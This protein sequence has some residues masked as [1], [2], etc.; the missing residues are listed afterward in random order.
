MNEDGA[1][2]PNWWRAEKALSLDRKKRQAARATAAKPGDAF[3]IVT[4]GTVTEPVYFDLLLS[5]LHLSA[6]LIKVLPGD[7]TDPKRVILTAEREAKEQLRRS[8][9]GLLG[10]NEPA[11]FDHVWAVVDTDVAA[12]EHNWNDVKQLADARKVKLAHSTPSFEFW[13]LLHFGLTTRADLV[14]GTAAKHAVK[15]AFKANH[16][17]DY[18]TDKPTAKKAIA[19]IVSKWQ[20]AIVYAEKVR[21][22]HKAAQTPAPANPS[23]EVDRLARALNDSAVQHYRKVPP[24]TA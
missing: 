16:D 20:E 15:D 1:C 5:D 6:V 19:A 24:P 4:E 8:R 7:G 18:S 23:T 11:K 12:R 2:D 3:L 13:L 21:H 9:K 10:L 22:Y 14:D 17:L